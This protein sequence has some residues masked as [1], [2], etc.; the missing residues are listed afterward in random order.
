MNLSVSLLSS[1][2]ILSLPSPLTFSSSLSFSI[3]PSLFPLYSPFS[4]HLPSSLLVP[5]L[6]FYIPP[7]FKLFLHSSF[8]PF[9]PLSLFFP[10]FLP[11]FLP[12][13]LFWFMSPFFL[14]YKGKDYVFIGLKSGFPLWGSVG[15]FWPV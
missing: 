12:A 5:F 11:S 14:Q 8:Y 10:C 4:F 2:F 1:I 15:C 7:S 6:S 13:F 3:P 9:F